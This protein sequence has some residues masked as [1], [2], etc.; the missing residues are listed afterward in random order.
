MDVSSFNSKYVIWFKTL[1]TDLKCFSYNFNF[2]KYLKQNPLGISSLNNP[3]IEIDSK[4]SSYTNHSYKNYFN[5]IFWSNNFGISSN[6]FS[7]SN[8]N[9]L[10]PK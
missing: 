6:L 8:D 7:D 3:I 9:D 10:I 4:V 1:N 2:V 5:S